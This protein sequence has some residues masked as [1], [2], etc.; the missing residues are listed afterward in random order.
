[1]RGGRACRDTTD[2]QQD[3][4]AHS[5]VSKVKEKEQRSYWDL[6]PGNQMGCWVHEYTKEHEKRSKFWMKSLYIKFYH[7]IKSFKIYFNVL[8]L[9]TKLENFLSRCPRC[10]LRSYCMLF[11]SFPGVHSLLCSDKPS[12]ESGSNSRDNSSL[13]PK[14]ITPHPFPP[15]PLRLPPGSLLLALHHTQKT[16]TWIPSL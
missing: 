6:E 15:Q 1:M 9:T 10:I 11:F 7:P 16:H 5:D 2:N 4:A 8:R 13:E 3:F 12:Y 14:L